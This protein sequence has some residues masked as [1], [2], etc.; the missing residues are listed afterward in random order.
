MENSTPLD[1]PLFAL[2]NRV[3]LRQ[4]H[5]YRENRG[6]SY[7]EVPSRGSVAAL[8]TKVREPAK[9]LFYQE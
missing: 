2:S 7:L 5:N 9:L 4:S 6:Q 3:R 1:P 8:L